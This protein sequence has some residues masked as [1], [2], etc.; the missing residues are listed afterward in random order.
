M[1]TLEEKDKEE[2]KKSIYSKKGTFYISFPKWKRLGGRMCRVKT[3][4]HLMG[5][6]GEYEVLKLDSL[7][8]PI[9][10]D[11]ETLDK[12]VKKWF[13]RKPFVTYWIAKWNIQTA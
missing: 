7:N 9:G 1:K 12:Y 11:R 13:I 10:I 5:L 3:E 4:I 8:H 2:Y 6:M